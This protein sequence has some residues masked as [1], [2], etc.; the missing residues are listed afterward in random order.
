[1]QAVVT[2]VHVLEQLNVPT[3]SAPIVTLAHV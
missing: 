1:M 3:G 2:K